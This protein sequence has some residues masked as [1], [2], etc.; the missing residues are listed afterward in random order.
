MPAI[1]ALPELR[2]VSLGLEM[3]AYRKRADVT[4]IQVGDE[5]S[6]DHHRCKPTVEFP[7]KFRLSRWV[8]RQM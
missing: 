5:E 3:A 6:N 8:N 4:T 2:L 7:Q 1:A